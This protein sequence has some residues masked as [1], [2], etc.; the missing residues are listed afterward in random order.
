MQVII[1]GTEYTP[2]AKPYKHKFGEII[3]M[4][5]RQLG[6]TRKTLCYAAGVSQSTM[7]R[8]ERGDLIPTLAVTTRIAYFLNLDLQR[9]AETV[10]KNP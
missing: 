5:R 3:E 2:R 7:H 8:V 4:R 9:L 10:L 1:D 6:V